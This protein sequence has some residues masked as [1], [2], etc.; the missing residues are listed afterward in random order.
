MSRWLAPLGL[1]LLV[2]S[3]LF[4]GN[5]LY[6]QDHPDAVV[7]A[8]LQILF[9]ILSRAGQVALPFVFLAFWLNRWQAAVTDRRVL[10]RRGFFS[11]KHDEIALTEV[12]DVRHDWD[13]QRLTLTGN[14]RDLAIHCGGRAAARLLE[15]LNE[16]YNPKP[17]LWQRLTSLIRRKKG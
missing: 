16:A 15:A 17:T 7:L 12:A 13:A 8:N 10:V 6:L 3:A 2:P 11:A 1:L 5:L 14:G 4:W 9:L